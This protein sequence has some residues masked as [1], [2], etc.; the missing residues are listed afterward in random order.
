MSEEELEVLALVVDNGSGVC[1]AGFA[2]ED[3]PRSVFSSIVGR[4][5]HEEVVKDLEKKDFYVGDEA[6]SRRSILTLTYPMEH[7]IITNWDDMEKVIL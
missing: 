5:C 1:K 3:G 6:Q 2:G 4:P 7:G